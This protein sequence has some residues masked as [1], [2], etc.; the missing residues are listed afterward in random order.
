MNLENVT[1]EMRP[2]SEWE[3]TDL[4]ARMIRRDAK[5]IYAVWFTVTLPFLALALLLN[6][7]TPYGALAMLL[8]WW[9]EPVADGAILRIISRRLFGEDADVTATLKAV[10]RLCWMNRIYLLS[11][12]RL[13]FARSVAMPVTQLEGLKGPARRTRSKVLNLRIF[14]YGVGITAV[15]A[16]LVMA[17]YLGVILIGYSFI[18]EIYRSTLGDSWLELFWMTSSTSA[19][20]IGLLSFY[21]AQSALQPWCVG[22]GFGLYINCRTQLE[23]WDVEVAFR[24]IVQRRAGVAAAIVL[25]MFILPQFL[26]PAMALAQ[27]PDTEIA[28]EAADPDPGFVGFWS[29][30]EVKPALKSVRSSEALQTTQRI[31]D[32]Q[33]IR[34]DETKEKQDANSSGWIRNMLNAVFKL[35]STALEF[36]LWIIVAILLI[37]MF[38]TRDRWL[39]YLGLPGYGPPAERRIFL[40]GG[41][42][43][44]DELPDDIVDAVLGAW[45]AGH[46]REALSLLYQG[47]VFAAVREHGVRLPRSAT[48]GA[49]VR[50]VSAQTDTERA[51]FF[52]RVVSVWIGCAYGDQEPDDDA[53]LPLCDEWRE[54]FG[55]TQ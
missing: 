21:I 41:E 23:A 9:F 19:T 43:T 26:S 29:D 42:L 37:M 54:H 51:N 12:Y 32:W 31:E 14:N 45:R 15:Y 50:A 53:V 18:P 13:H 1:I 34:S 46:K 28:A 40:A 11:P 35:V 39:P 3:A 44:A 2:R 33:R 17:L 6:F 8:Y 5:A 38:L 48:E 27:E 36:A 16:H 4:G 30:D 47:S 52:R 7:L 10:P 22:A 49:C 24:R 25:A 55:A 20:A